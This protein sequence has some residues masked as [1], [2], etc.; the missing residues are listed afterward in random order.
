M[1]RKF[2]RLFTYAFTTTGYKKLVVP[3][4]LNV[5]KIATVNLCSTIKYSFSKLPAHQVLSV[6]IS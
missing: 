1:I 6:F 5:Q 3:H 2:S 4:K